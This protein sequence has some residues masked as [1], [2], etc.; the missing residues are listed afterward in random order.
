MSID[1]NMY[2]IAAAIR[3]I[4][5]IAEF[6]IVEDNLDSIEW[7]VTSNGDLDKEAILSAIPIVKKA[8]SDKENK[9]KNDK[10]ALL[11]RL[12]ITEEEAKLLLG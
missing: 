1:E 7:I 5:P 8:A 9:N 2:W 11:E 12:G 10:K 4:D 6:T 3:H